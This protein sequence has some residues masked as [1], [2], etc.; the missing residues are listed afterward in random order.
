MMDSNAHP[1]NIR[2]QTSFLVA[3]QS[4]QSSLYSEVAD[5]FMPNGEGPSH[6]PAIHPALIEEL[7]DWI[8]KRGFE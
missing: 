8:E 7:H 3:N 6:A 5:G 2:S 1:E 4:N